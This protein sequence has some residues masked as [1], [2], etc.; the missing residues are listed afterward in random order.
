MQSKPTQSKWWWTSWIPVLN[1]TK[2]EC[3][4]R[5]RWA[6]NQY[7]I[8]DASGEKYQLTQMEQ[9]RNIWIGMNT[10]ATAETICYQGP[11]GQWCV[12]KPNSCHITSLN[13]IACLC[14]A[15]EELVCVNLCL[16]ELLHLARRKWTSGAGPAL[17]RVSGVPW[18]NAWTPS[19][20]AI[21]G[22]PPTITS[23][24][25]DWMYW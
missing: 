25:F 5:R 11:G 12:P 19:F 8:T 7:W 1:E 20:S 10:D 17:M 21:R 16:H 15:W 18:T 23:F 3:Q 9:E 22:F 24:S 13:S 2:N 14:P 4:I 6:M